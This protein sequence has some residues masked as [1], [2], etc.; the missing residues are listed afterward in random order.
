MHI[1]P[2]SI[3]KTTWHKVLDY[4]ASSDLAPPYLLID[5]D[6]V[7]GKV[8]LIGKKIRNSKV[9]YAVKAH[10]DAA[11]VD[12]LNTLGVGFEIASEG[13][14]DILASLGV[15]P[16]R[17]ITSNPVKSPR[18]LEQ[19]VAYGMK[20]YAFDSAAE[21]EKLA[22]YAP[23]A[24]VYVRL[25][26]PNEGSE[27]PLSKKFGVEVDAAEELLVLAKKKGLNPIGLTFH[28]GSQCTNMYNWNSAL[29]YLL[30]G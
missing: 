22:R 25:S 3:S 19:A 30:A 6:I 9:F 29:V 11:I 18:F 15:A 17:I 16:E 26:V 21:V 12:F 8:L 1:T 10:P 5:R 2:E 23:G 28:V 24:G 14:L 20:S 13:E 27:W 4:I 7:R